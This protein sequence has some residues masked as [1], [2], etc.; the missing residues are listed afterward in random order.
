MMN[1]T[2]VSQLHDARAWGQDSQTTQMDVE[3]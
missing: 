1:G 2:E 3:I